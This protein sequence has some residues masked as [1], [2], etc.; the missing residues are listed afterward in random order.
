[1]AKLL[2]QALLQRIKDKQT[3]VATNATSSLVHSTPNEPTPWGNTYSYEA[4]YKLYLNLAAY[5]ILTP[6]IIPPL[7]PYQK[8]LKKLVPLVYE[9]LYASGTFYSMVAL[10]KSLLAF[11]VINSPSI[12]DYNK[13]TNTLLASLSTEVLKDINAVVYKLH[14]QQ[15]VPRC[16]K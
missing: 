14:Y 9:K 11:I 8:L 12:D 2:A 6:T 5:Y 10:D 13:I 3:Q 1:M 16:P 4:Q 7:Y 15:G